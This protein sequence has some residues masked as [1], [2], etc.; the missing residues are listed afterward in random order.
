MSKSIEKPLGSK[1]YGSIPHLIG[2]RTGPADHTVSEG[3]HKICTLKVRDRHD[4]IVVQ[5]KLDGSCVAVA[6][7]DGVIVPL[8]RA[9]YRAETSPFEQHQLFA[10]WVY[11]NQQR[12]LDLLYNNERLCG[13]WLAQAHGTRY[14]LR[15]EPFVAFDL[16]RNLNGEAERLIY[17]DFCDRVIGKF[18]IPR[19][20]SAGNYPITIE[21]VM[22]HL[23]AY[24]DKHGALD[25]IEGAVW[26]VERKDKVEYLAK[27]VRQ[28][29]ED[30]KYLESVSGQP[31]VWNWR[32]DW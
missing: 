1:A 26:R 17:S 31:A 18:A 14:K 15:H 23:D 6:K 11:A 8:I 30:G 5:E 19:M 4:N 21:R 32:P 24:P 3:Q 10:Q 12:F 9:G 16:I 20:I 13:E 22:A 25:P 29:K 28:G 27:F 7:I 2:S